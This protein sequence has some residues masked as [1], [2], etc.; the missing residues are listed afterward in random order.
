MSKRV[1]VT[2]ARGG[3]LRIWDREVEGLQ[4]VIGADVAEGIVRDQGNVSRSQITTRDERDFSAAIVLE[5]QSG[6][7]VASWHGLV[8]P[9]RYASILAALGMLYNTALLVPER[10]GPGIAVVHALVNTIRYPRLY[11]DKF[12]DPTARSDPEANIGWQTNRTSRK[13]LISRIHEWLEDRRATTRDAA[14]L[15]EMR[16]VQLTRDGTERAQG[17]DKDDR[18]MALGMALQG[19]F[20]LL[21]NQLQRQKNDKPLTEDQ[22]H[23]LEVKKH[24][25]EGDRNKHVRVHTGGYG[26]LPRITASG[27]DVSHLTPGVGDG[28]RAPRVLPPVFR[29]GRL[30]P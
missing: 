25:N 24:L 11:V 18:V 6:A 27:C 1:L 4:Y 12:F 2:E 9:H 19:R 20:E 3:A 14:L 29:G 21:T 28:A 10:N 13:L 8:E 16:S 15:K 17:L 30:L 7:H 22:R 23:W 26:S 5:V